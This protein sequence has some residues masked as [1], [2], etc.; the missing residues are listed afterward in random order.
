[1]D[2]PKP[3]QKPAQLLNDLESIRQLLGDE[4]LEPPLL[5]DSLDP[6]SIPLLS[7][8]VTPPPSAAAPKPIPPAA[9]PT[10]RDTVS[11]SVSRDSEVNR[12]DSELRAAA[13]LI[14]QDVIDDFVPQ[15][16]AELKRRLEA[17]LT[18]LLPPRRP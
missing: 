18:R 12:L 6:D 8:I 10:L 5:I 1:M 17:R 14:L 11:Q 3:P 4:N 15:I 2:T 7:E 13:Q 16:E 9:A